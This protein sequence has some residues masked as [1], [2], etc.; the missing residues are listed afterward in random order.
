MDDTGSAIKQH[1][2]QHAESTFEGPSKPAPSSPEDVKMVNAANNEDSAEPTEPASLAQYHREN[3]FLFVDPDTFAENYYYRSEARDMRYSEPT[4]LRTLKRE[5][6]SL[7]ENLP[8]GI[9][10]RCEETRLDEMKVLII[11]P[12][13]TPYENGFFEF[14]VLCPD[15]YPWEP[16]KM[17]FRTTGRTKAVFN[18][19]LYS[20]GTGEYN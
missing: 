4:R 12:N 3:C 7:M 6:A 14:D 18:P 5:I 11:G 20:S 1:E 8:E 17:Q 10:V 13:D 9:Y 2:V 19:N 15:K 16:P